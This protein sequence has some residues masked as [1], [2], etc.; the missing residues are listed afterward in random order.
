MPKSMIRFLLISAF[1]V[2]LFSC[3]PY[4]ITNTVKKESSVKEFKN[5]YFAN[6]ETDYVYKAHIDVYGNELSGIFIAKRMND[7]IHRVVFTTD[8]GNKLLDFELS[9]TEFKVN[10]ILEDL[11]KKIV[12]NTLRDDFRLLLR[13]DHKV[14]ESLENE[15]F[16]I[17]KSA[18]KKRFNYFF[19]NKTDGKLVKLI[20][21]SKSKEKVVFGFVSK[22]STFAENIT[23]QHKN[24]KLK[25]ELNQITNQSN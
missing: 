10:Y 4:E 3:K 7:S 14:A 22:N 16:Y 2:L 11:N 25:I 6:P 17:Y 19:V 5:Q 18:D 1:S 12:V 23:I 8:F 24:I 20:N 15:E 21:A 9:E 13:V